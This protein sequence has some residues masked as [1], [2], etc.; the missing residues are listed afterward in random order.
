M[1][2]RKS[3]PVNT[4]SGR[5][6]R[7]VSRSTTCSTAHEAPNEEHDGLEYCALSNAL[8]EVRGVMARKYRLVP[9]G[10]TSNGP[11]R[12]ARLSNPSHA[13]LDGALGVQDHHWLNLDWPAARELEIVPTDECG[14]Y[15]EHLDNRH[16]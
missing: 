10:V 1:P 7:S 12:P 4:Q 5:P 8:G 13:H 3:A 2:S 6:S 14:E 9:R 11:G 15:H 16:A